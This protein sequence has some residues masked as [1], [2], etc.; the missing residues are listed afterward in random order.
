MS[1]PSSTLLFGFPPR[2]SESKIDLDIP[3]GASARMMPAARGR[4]ISARMVRMIV[5]RAVISTM[6][7]VASGMTSAMFCPV[8]VSRGPGRRTTVTAPPRLPGIFMP[9]PGDLAQMLLPLLLT[10]VLIYFP[11]AFRSVCPG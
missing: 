2:D 5:S 6:I 8:T 9:L 11:I 7:A 4:R 1:S 10:P 3:S